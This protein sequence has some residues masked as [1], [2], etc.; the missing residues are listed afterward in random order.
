MSKKRS[1]S[2][3]KSTTKS[4]SGLRVLSLCAMVIL[5]PAVMGADDTGCASESSG[6]VTQDRIYSSYWLLY[7]AE[8]DQTFA[9]AQFRVGSNIGTTLVLDQGDEVTFDGRAMPFN[10]LLDWHEAIIPG[11][12]TSGAFTY[13]NTEGDSFINAVIPFVEAGVSWAFPTSLPVSSS[14]DLVWDGAALG[15]GETVEATVARASNR[16]DFT[17]FFARGTGTTSVVFNAS[18]LSSVGPGGA[19]LVLRRSLDAPLDEGTAAGGKFTVTYQTAE[20]SVSDHPEAG[21]R[22]NAELSEAAPIAFRGSRTAR[23]DC[24]P[25]WPA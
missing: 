14:Y 6:A 18:G 20:T 22:R 17:S 10:A 1:Y 23:G 5:A 11:R 21:V 19:V 7:D 15:E 2:N 16:F 3:E 24:G 12:V 9:R 25:D 4:R 8:A 13:V